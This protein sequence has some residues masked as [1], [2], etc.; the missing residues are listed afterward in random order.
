[1]EPFTDIYQWRGSDISNIVQF[2]DRYKKVKA[3]KLESNRRSRPAIVECANKFAQ[4]IPGRLE[5]AMISVRPDASPSVYVWSSET[6]VS[7][8]DIIAEH[9]I[10]LKKSGWQYRD[11]AVLFRSVRTSAPL[12]VSALEE[13]KIPYNCGGRTGL[14]AHP[15]INCFGELFAW[16][17][18]FSWQDE[19][20]GPSR[21]ATVRKSDQAQHLVC[22]KIL[23]FSK[24]IAAITRSANRDV[25]P[26]YL[27][28]GF[29]RHRHLAGFKA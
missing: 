8:S 7:E 24:Y 16:I 15:E 22:L 14:F 20:F 4:S 10:A 3:I 28:Y 26:G 6:P 18:G 1:L 17:A 23:K 21:D 27:L 19:R 13:R 2:A 29:D 12:L 5:K 11:I 9:I 25:R